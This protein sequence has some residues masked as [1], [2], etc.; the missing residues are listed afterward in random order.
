[1]TS[2]TADVAHPGG[3]CKRG[4]SR[5]SPSRGSGAREVDIASSCGPRRRRPRRLC[6]PRGARLETLAAIVADYRL[7]DAA[8]AQEDA[9]WGDP[10]LALAET[11]RRACASM[12]VYDKKHSHQACIPVEVLA[13]AGDVLVRNRARLES[14]ADFEALHETVRRLIDPMHGVGALQVYD[15]S[16]RIGL[17]L[18][19]EPQVV[20]L[21][22]GV[23]KGAEGLGLDIRGR[24][25][26][27]PDELPGPLARLTA[28]E[29]EDVL[30]IYKDDLLAMPG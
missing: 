21:H 25:S 26:V 13:A 7:D 16:T 5:P 18:G 17:R 19:L 15:F 29:A 9:F 14:C 24:T 28:A 3:L 4:G 6:R 11:I 27:R 1:M 2:R 20:H 23:V 8:R 10:A 22:A 12:G 30:C